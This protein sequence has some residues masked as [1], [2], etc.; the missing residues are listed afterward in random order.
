MRFPFISAILLSAVAVSACATPVPLRVSN[1]LPLP[2]TKIAATCFAENNVANEDLKTGARSFGGDIFLTK[3]SQPT[4]PELIKSDLDELCENGFDSARKER[5]VRISITSASMY[6]KRDAAEAVPFLGIATAFNERPVVAE[7]EF[8]FEFEEG[9]FVQRTKSF[10]YKAEIMHSVATQSDVAAAMVAA[11]E[12][13]RSEAFPKIYKE[14]LS[15][16]A[17]PD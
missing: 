14:V 16:Y 7:A 5:A 10:T 15:R 1:E 8:F 9:G 2:P 13:F 12:Q 6:Y 3:A 4:F 17:W 11:A